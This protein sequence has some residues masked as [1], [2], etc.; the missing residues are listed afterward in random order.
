MG[1]N[2]TQEICEESGCWFKFGT[3]LIPV[4]IAGNPSFVLFRAFEGGIHDK[5][6]HWRCFDLDLWDDGQWNLESLST[7]IPNDIR[8]G[9]LAVPIPRDRNLKDCVVWENSMAGTYTPHLGYTWLLNKSRHME[10]DTGKWHW[11]LTDNRGLPLAANSVVEDTWHFVLGDSRRAWE[12]YGGS[13]RR[14]TALLF[15][16]HYEGDVWLRRNIWRMASDSH[17][18]WGED[19]KGVACNLLPKLLAIA[20]GLK[21]AWDRGYRKIICHSDSKD[22]LRLLSANQVGFHKYRALIF[23]IRELL[24]RDWTVRIAHTFRE[25]NFCADFMAKFATSCDNGLMIWDEPPQGLQQLLLADIMGIS[26]PR[27]V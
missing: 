14:E 12:L 3:I 17:M 1:A 9:I 2:A 20:K 22:A 11:R 10:D 21:L 18:A 25:A 26:F 6:W 27:I 23:E 15:G 4:L 24:R 5:A 13:R 7:V 8:F 19:M 16:N